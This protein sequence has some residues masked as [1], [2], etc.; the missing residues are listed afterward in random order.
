MMTN[1]TQPVAKM[2]SILRAHML[3]YTP[4][5]SGSS[6]KRL[7]RFFLNDWF[8]LFVGSVAFNANDSYDASQR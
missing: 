2:S 7:P 8:E 4:Q 6:L 5:L 3:L 1:G